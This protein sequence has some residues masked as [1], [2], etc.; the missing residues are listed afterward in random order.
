MLTQQNTTML[1]HAPF[2]IFKQLHAKVKVSITDHEA[3]YHVINVNQ[4]LSAWDLGISYSGTI[5]VVRSWC[6]LSS[7]HMVSVLQIIEHT[8]LADD[9]SLEGRISFSVEHS[10]P[11]QWSE[12]GRKFNQSLSSSGQYKHKITATIINMHT[13]QLSLSVISVSL[14]ESI[15]KVNSTW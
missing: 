4:V 8:Y 9:R 7:G 5:L 14:E 3:P 2:I 12:V 6:T 15:K 10:K 1:G 11:F 13:Y